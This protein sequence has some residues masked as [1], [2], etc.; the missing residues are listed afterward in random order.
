MSSF[1]LIQQKLE[2]FIKKYYTSE[3]IKGTIFFFAAG[4]LYFLLTLLIEYF[5]WLNPLGRTILFWTF[6]LVELALFMRFIAFTLLKL[7]S[8]QKGITNEQAAQIIGDHFPEVNDKLLNVLQ[9]NQNQRESDL[10]AASI[11]QKSLQM[12]SV[13]FKKAINFQKNL[14]YLVFAAIP[15]LVFGVVSALGEKDLFASSYK[16]VVNYDTAYAPPAPF[17]FYI[18]NKDLSAIQNKPFTLKIRIK[19]PCR[20]ISLI[21]HSRIK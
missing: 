4:F 12:Q 10:L 17:S 16:R 18:V 19:S 20:H 3:L 7:F 14:K 15:I 2:Q 13:V 21:E 9:L 8:L 11:D 1:S 6:V 5:L